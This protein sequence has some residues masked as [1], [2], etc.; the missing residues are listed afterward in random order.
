MISRERI[1]DP[2]PPE[3]PQTWGVPSVPHSQGTAAILALC[4]AFAQGCS[5]DSPSNPSHPSTNGPADAWQIPATPALRIGVADGEPPYVFS[6]IAG[7]RRLTSGPIVVADGGTMEL[8]WF[9][10]TGVHLFTR[11]RDGEGP[12]EFR[13]IESL[14][15]TDT[16][17]LVAFDF[18][19]QRLTFFGA[20]GGLLRVLALPPLSLAPYLRPA[21][22]FSDGSVLVYAERGYDL[23]D[24]GTVVGGEATY[25]RIRSN[26][27]EVD[28]LGAFP[29]RA[30][31]IYQTPTGGLTPVFKPF[32]ATPRRAVN[33]ED[34]YFGTAE[35]RDVQVFSADGRPRRIVTLA[36]EG[37]PVTQEVIH[38]YRQERL[39]SIEN[40][41]ARRNR[42]DM[43]GRVGFPESMPTLSGLLPDGAGNLWVEGFRPWEDSECR[44]FV[45]DPQGQPLGSVLVLEDLDVEQIGR[46]FVLGLR[47]DELG[48]EYVELYRLVKPTSG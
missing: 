8:R 34:F 13:G 2:G 7:A 24:V 43:V 6:R 10:S 42:E 22:V 19:L 41:V 20:D 23:N 33:G 45:F 18:W 39:A 3:D 1:A 9:D 28:T 46:D 17:N 25:Y 31:Y 37:A 16:D 14:F 35:G 15:V 30:Y 27:G 44:W 12:G 38:R 4:L 48:V 47:E 5:N 40:P 32:Q 26:G 29:A 21:G 11:G 36:E